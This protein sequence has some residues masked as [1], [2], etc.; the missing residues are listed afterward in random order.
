MSPLVY[1]IIPARAGSKGVPGKNLRDLGGLPLLAHSVC[2]A[3]GAGCVGRILLSTDSLEIA[4]VGKAYG[5]ET[6]FLRPDDLAGD[7]SPVSDAVCHL[8]ETLS[9]VEGVLPDYLLLLQPTSP[10]RTSDDIDSA[11][12][13]LQQ[14]G[15][16]ALVSVTEAQSHP[17]LCR[18]IGDDGVLAP[19]IDSPLNTARRQ[20]LP[21]AYVLNGA[22]YLI[23]TDTFLESGS[24]CPPGAIAYVMPQDRSL[25]IDTELDLKQA[26]FQMMQR[27]VV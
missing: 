13:L 4:E 19:F 9:H 16:H 12:R 11:F 10:F 1:A 25:D 7:E 24:F 8:V 23:R 6:P 17:L 5:A 2:A 26:E 21:P 20:D 14:S 15:G 27:G 18:A 22:V 3:A